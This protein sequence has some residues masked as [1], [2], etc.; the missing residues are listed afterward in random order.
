MDFFTRFTRE[1]TPQN[2]FSSQNISVENNYLI[3]LLIHLSFTCWFLSSIIIMISM[4]FQRWFQTITFIW[5]YQMIIFWLNKIFSCMIWTQL[6]DPLVVLLD[7]LWD[8]HF[9]NVQEILWNSYFHCGNLELK[10]FLIFFSSE[11]II[12]NCI[13]IPQA[14]ILSKIKNEKNI[15]MIKF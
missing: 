2:N 3:T 9:Y 8:F 11:N 12:Y 5:L 13:F 1:K 15:C 4:V 14:L 6:L 7:Y 10:M